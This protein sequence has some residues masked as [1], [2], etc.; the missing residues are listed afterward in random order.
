MS[1]EKVTPKRRWPKTIAAI[2]IGFVAIVVIYGLVAYLGWQ[3]GQRERTTLAEEAVRTQIVRQIELAQADLNSGNVELALT[4]IDWVLERAPQDQQALTIKQTAQ[5]TLSASTSP[6]PTPTP[7]P[8]PAVV[9]DSAETERTELAYL[10][11]LNETEEWE[12]AIKAIHAFQL[13]YPDTDR[14]TTDKLLFEAYLNSG[15]ELAW[16]DRIELGLTHLERAEALGLLP[17]NALDQQVISEL[18]LN[19][20]SYYGVRW[21][22]AIPN[23]Q[24]ICDVTPF[25][26]DSCE[27]LAAAKALYGDQWAFADEY[28][29][30]SN[31]YAQAVLDNDSA[32][33]RT[34][35]IDARE[36]CAAA[37]PTPTATPELPEETPEP[38][39]EP[40]PAP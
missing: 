32:E 18:Y 35:L 34:K 30:A 10:Q 7:E 26:L 14:E 8:T 11:R 36:K 21:D 20:L 1:V 40:T 25:Y 2:L 29:P 6:T 38:G 4:R 28:C 16:S 3:S 13:E 22:V 23:F 19:G 31:W 39:E 9:D 33:N 15:M 5:S 37:T 24:Q 12:Q 17:Q 27:R